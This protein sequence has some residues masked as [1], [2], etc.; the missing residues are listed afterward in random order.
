MLRRRQRRRQRAQAAAQEPMKHTMKMKC[1]CAERERM[2]GQRVPQAAMASGRA[3]TGA[4]RSRGEQLQQQVRPRV[5]RRGVGAQQRA[6]AAHA[7][8]QHLQRARGA[9][10]RETERT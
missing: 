4:R 5:Q 10:R 8:Q 1:S 2:L 3:A 7:P 9:H 6:D